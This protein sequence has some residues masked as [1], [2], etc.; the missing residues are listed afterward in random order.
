MK[1]LCI[2]PYIHTQFV[3][4]ISPQTTSFNFV[5]F[6]SILEHTLTI[7]PP[8]DVACYSMGQYFSGRGWMEQVEELTGEG[9]E[10]VIMRKSSVHICLP[11]TFS[12]PELL[13]PVGWQSTGQEE[14]MSLGRH[15]LIG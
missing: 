11:L 12:S 5:V 6:C 8:K 7:L 15:N 13:V 1:K 3:L 14:Q 4:V 9:L 2:T 10:I